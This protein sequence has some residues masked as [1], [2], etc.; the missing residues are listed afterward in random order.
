LNP[1]REVRKKTPK[2]REEAFVCKFCGHANHL[3]EF[4][5]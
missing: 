5:F 4:C 1:K 3:D 2:P